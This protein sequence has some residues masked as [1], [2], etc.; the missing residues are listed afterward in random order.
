MKSMQPLPRIV[1]RA[2]ALAALVSGLTAVTHAQVGG[3]GWSSYSPTKKQDVRGS[4]A[5][6]SNSSGIETF[7]IYPGDER[8]ETRVNNNYTSGWN[9]FEGQVKVTS[10]TTGTCVHQVFGGQTNATALMIVAHSTSGGDLRR[11]DSQTLATGV[12]GVWLRIN[13]VHDANGNKVSA[14]INGS[15][16]GTWDDRGNATH[17]NKYGVYNIS[18]SKSQ[19]QWKSVKFWRK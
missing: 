7:T 19:T 18:G 16:K 8:S 15:N 6:Y 9:Q 2:L 14:Y 1:V 3:S 17:Y 5:T 13:T 4:R 12:Y 10:G 11:Y